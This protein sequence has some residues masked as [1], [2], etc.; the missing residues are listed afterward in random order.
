MIKIL[1]HCICH[2]KILSSA[3]HKAQFR[4]CAYTH[5]IPSALFIWVK[6]LTPKSWQKVQPRF[7][8][9]HNSWNP[10]RKTDGSFIHKVET[11]V[12]RNVIVTLTGIAPSDE[13]F[14]WINSSSTGLFLSKWRVISLKDFTKLSHKAF[15]YYIT[16]IYSKDSRIENV[17]KLKTEV[18]LRCHP[19]FLLR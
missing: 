12:D 2:P 6:S 11:R 17:R 1:T 4:N 7:L 14:R 9:R 10:T 5:I 16:L 18:G 13:S 15:F 19:T 3:L 8:S